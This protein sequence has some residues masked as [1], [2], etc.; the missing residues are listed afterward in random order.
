MNIF[1]KHFLF[2][3]LFLCLSS[4]LEGQIPENPFKAPLY[5]SVYENHIMAEK[6][7]ETGIY[8]SE[9]DFS[10][11]INWVDTNLKDFGYT[12]ICIDG[13]GDVKQINANGYRT[14][15]STN[16][17]HDYAWWSD[18]LQKRGM[19]LGMYM[20]PL[21]LHVADN[22][23]KTLIAGTEI[24]VS[25][26]K[27]PSEI[28]NFS[29][30]QIDHPGAE[31]YV[32][33]YIQFYADMGVK[34]L[35][36]DFLSW[37]ENG[38]DR[39]LGRV[40]P[41]RP[42]EYYETAL[43][44]MREA[45]DAN[46][47]FLSLVMPHL[48][49]D[50]ATEQKYGHMVRIN[51]DCG[52]G[53]WYK[54][55]DNARGLHREGWSQY[56]NPFDGFIYWSKIAGRGKMI[57]D[58]DFI[59]LNSFSSVEERKSVV[60]MHLMAGGPVSIA[61]QWNTIGGNLWIYQNEEILALNEDGFVGKP[62]SNDPLNDSSQIWTGKMSNGDWVV[63]FFN[64]EG[65]A[66]TRE[67][68]FQDILGIPEGF[69][70]DLW[71]HADLGVMSSLSKSI[72]SHRCQ[73]FR[74]SAG[75][76]KLVS[77]VFSIK[78]G[79]YPVAKTISLSSSTIGAKIY[80][81]RDGT[82]PSLSSYEYTSPIEV[83][84][85]ETIKAVAVKEGMDGSYISKEIYFIGEAPAQGGMY[86]GGTFN[87]W[88]LLNA[89]M[90][91]MG[92]NNWATEKIS[93]TA[94]SQQ[95]K[96]ANQYNWKGTDWGNASGLTG[97]AKIT[98]GGSANIS[99]TAPE[100]GDYII[101]FNDYT[102]QYSI[103]KVLDSQQNEMYIG[104]TFNSWNLSQ[105][106]MELVDDNLWSSDSILLLAGNQMVKFANT[107]DWSGVDWGRSYG[108]TGTAKIST[109]GLPNISF[110]VP[111]DEK[112]VFTFNDKTLAYSIISRTTDIKPTSISGISLY[113]NPVSDRL[114][115]NIENETSARVT[116]YSVSGKILHDAL[117]S[118]KPIVLDMKSLTGSGLF[119]VKLTT[120]SIVRQ[121]EIF[122]Y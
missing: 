117:E 80:F 14:S 112:Y 35:R 45:C 107:A 59:R 15:H 42:H 83:T 86:V 56:A 94:G 25:T 8:I 29:W 114:S 38:Q 41:D 93:I 79:S 52:D 108:F 88:T 77:P 67:I 84:S 115:I 78:G 46:G 111:R 63:G 43:R 82:M 57:L 76:N 106:K 81:T 102:L 53:E 74:I 30:C 66:K 61:D 24:P 33:G 47:M 62:L 16:W 20:N 48:F 91:Y 37:F 100:S 116:I 27:D 1:R 95:L 36:V 17:I 13:W 98:T 101:R 122:V 34:F 21:W 44:W 11:N 118:G 110:T 64:R 28:S 92:S 68:N 104:G 69:V 4:F 96:F 72:A 103:T 40:G 89:P 55:S 65:S 10:D 70:R 22:D 32:K 90:N 9:K 54:F 26:L 18:T 7:G 3:F 75:I 19:T 58:G 105:S 113:P 73:I 121:F 23:T 71:T 109:G 6:A 51:E 120:S 2:L 50:A 87:G 31:Q 39:Y 97:I 99:F 49:D 12:I 5:W 85:S 119:V 60:S